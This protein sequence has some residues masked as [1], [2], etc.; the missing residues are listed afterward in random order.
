MRLRR[1][2][3]IHPRT[4][5]TT[6]YPN[7]L[8]ILLRQGHSIPLPSN[9]APPVASTLCPQCALRFKFCHGTNCL[10]NRIFTIATSHR[11]S[12]LDISRVLFFSSI[13]SFAL[14]YAKQDSRESN[15]RT[16]Q[17]DLNIFHLKLIVL[18]I[19]LFSTS[20]LYE[21]NILTITI[22]NVTHV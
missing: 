21:S 13:F 16:V 5:F 9:F 17:N 3:R 1:K 8:W 14:S 20:R 4:R 11:R 7:P 10:T 19:D 6:Y 2:F 18:F 12:K 15:R 22:L